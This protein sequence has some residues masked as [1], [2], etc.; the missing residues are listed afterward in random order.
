MT[1]S[2][3]RDVTPMAEKHGK[4]RSERPNGVR[5][6]QPLFWISRIRIARV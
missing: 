3:L 1:P 4:R 5:A 6:R 2:D